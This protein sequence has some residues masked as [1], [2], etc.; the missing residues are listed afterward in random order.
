[1]SSEVNPMSADWLD[2]Y[3]TAQAESCGEHVRVAVAAERERVKRHALTE[4]M[5][6]RIITGLELRISD[7]AGS[8]SLPAES[9][10][11]GAGSGGPPSAPPPVAP[12]PITK[13]QR[14]VLD[15][16]REELV[17]LR[18]GPRADEVWFELL[19]IHDATSTGELSN[20]EAD[21]M[22]ASLRLEVKQ[23]A[24]FVPPPVVQRTLE[25][26]AS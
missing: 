18:G 13:A 11:S 21:A 25:E 14:G 20:V 5:A 19:G 7:S 12:K 22:E 17:G 10:L 3:L 1:M 26:Q 16:L 15:K 2:G 4:D 9:A 23:A 8:P 24:E 6:A